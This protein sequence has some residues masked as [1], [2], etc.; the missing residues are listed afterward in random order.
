L[1]S[2]W[3]KRSPKFWLE[4]HD[5]RLPLYVESWLEPWFNKIHYRVRWSP[6]GQMVNRHTELRPHLVS[7]RL[8]VPFHLTWHAQQTFDPKSAVN[9][10]VPSPHCEHQYRAKQ[11]VWRHRCQLLPIILHRGGSHLL[12]KERMAL[13]KTHWNSLLFDQLV[14]YYRFVLSYWNYHDDSRNHYRTL[15]VQ[16]LLVLSIDVLVSYS[17]YAF[18]SE[19]G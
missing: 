8:Q 11:P 13:G 5:S 1:A 9:D 17:V 19:D 3:T 2:N 4:I 15:W 14:E 7:D 18:V 12:A 16:C 10:H 6:R